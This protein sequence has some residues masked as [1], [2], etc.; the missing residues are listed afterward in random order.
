MCKECLISDAFRVLFGFFRDKIIFGMPSGRVVKVGWD[1]REKKGGVR[2]IHRIGNISPMNL[3]F[4]LVIHRNQLSVKA[5]PESKFFFF[6]SLWLHLSSEI[7]KNKIFLFLSSFLF[8]SF[9]DKI[10]R[11]SS[12]ALH[13]FFSLEA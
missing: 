6:Y 9:I 13:S 1:V 2:A 7:K 8:T 4:Y 5:F 3:S 12:K 11:M 10:L